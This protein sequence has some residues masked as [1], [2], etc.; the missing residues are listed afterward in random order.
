[1]QT[2][3]VKLTVFGKGFAI[4]VIAKNYEDAK[5]KAIARVSESIEFHQVEQVYKDNSDKFFKDFFEFINR[6]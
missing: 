5:I 4:N 6:K 2:Y 3:K 1:M